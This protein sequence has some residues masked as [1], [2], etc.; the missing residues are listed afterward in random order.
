M[1]LFR[2]LLGEV[3]VLFTRPNAL[4]VDGAPDRC[5]WQVVIDAAT[6]ARP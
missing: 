1:V 5:N 2:R 4:S 6:S 3:G